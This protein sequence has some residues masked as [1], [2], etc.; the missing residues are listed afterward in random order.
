MS[1]L[2][3]FDSKTISDEDMT[4][5]LTKQKGTFKHT[6]VM[7]ER[8]LVTKRVALHTVTSH[9]SSQFPDKLIF[10]DES[11]MFKKMARMA[12]IYGCQIEY[13]F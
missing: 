4:V 12:E 5:E 8:T 10:S 7:T 6:Y 2:I 13:L 11:E 9:R 1:G 3:I